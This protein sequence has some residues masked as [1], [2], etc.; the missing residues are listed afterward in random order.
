MLHIGRMEGMKKNEH[1]NDISHSAPL[2]PYPT[3]SIHPPIVTRIWPSLVRAVAEDYFSHP[4]LSVNAFESRVLNVTHFF[5]VLA[6][7][8]FLKQF[9]PTLL[10]KRKKFAESN[11]SLCGGFFF[12][13]TAFPFVFCGHFWRFLGSSLCVVHGTYL[14]VANRR[15]FFLENT[16]C[17][18]CNHSIGRWQC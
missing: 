6:A 12:G 3:P 18:P 8:I 17:P 4:S 5:S 11:V 7:W 1:E 13:E 9:S 16:F 15:G 10:W 2:P 14:T